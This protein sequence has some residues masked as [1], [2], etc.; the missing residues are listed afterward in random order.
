MLT[1]RLHPRCAAPSSSRSGFTLVELLV[2]IGIIAILA[3]VALGP[4]TSGIKK[5]QQSSGV[6]TS[7]TVALSEF[8][9][10]NDNNQTYPFG[11]DA[12]KVANL[13]VQGNY[14]QDP[15]IFVIS[16]S[17]E[18]KYTGTANPAN[19][20]TTNVSWDFGES[21]TT[22]GLTPNFPDQTPVVVSTTGTAN[23]WSSG[24]TAAGP[25][26][27]T[28]T[29]ATLPFGTAGIA[30]CFKSNSAKF[31]TA[32][33]TGTTAAVTLEDASWQAG[34]TIVRAAGGG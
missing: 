10:A 8:Q 6:Q 24:L 26:S 20:Q 30:V 34:T 25:V 3:G 16:G 17:T 18:S 32:T 29:S 12:G 1:N 21:S 7:R 22:A 23:D 4:I 31:L 9:Y 15:G 27:V 5:A 11:T 28:L 2:V 19:Y 14:I 33:I 13:L